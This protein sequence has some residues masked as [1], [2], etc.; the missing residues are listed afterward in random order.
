[1]KILTIEYASSSLRLSNSVH[2]G[3]FSIYLSNSSHLNASTNLGSSFC[4]H[5][6][7]TPIVLRTKITS[8]P[9]ISASI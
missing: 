8:L 3:L 4:L 7:G 5:A 6:D 9:L 2:S 1:M